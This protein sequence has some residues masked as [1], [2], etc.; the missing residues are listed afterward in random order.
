MRSFVS[1]Q[2]TA[3]AIVCSAYPD[4]QRLAVRRALS[5]DR[6]IQ[7]LGEG[8]EKQYDPKIVDLAV[9]LLERKKSETQSLERV[10]ST[11]SHELELQVT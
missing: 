1:P 11:V 8:R 3:S 9:E 7:I 4:L 10:D 6:V 2:N 5:I